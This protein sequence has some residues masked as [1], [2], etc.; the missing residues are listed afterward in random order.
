MH[1]NEEDRVFIGTWVSEEVKKAVE[2]GYR[3]GKIFEIWQ[4]KITQY[5]PATGQGGLFPGYID[6]FFKQKTLA[7]GF[8]AECNNDPEA[9]D[10]YIQDFERAEGIKLDKSQINLNPGKRSVAKLCLNSLWGKYGQREN[11]PKTEIVTELQR[12]VEMLTTPEV[13]VI[14]YLPANDYTLYVYWRYTEEAMETSPVTN[15]VVAAYT[16][17]Q[18]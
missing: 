9:I 12:L 3:T 7:S 5:N 6:E 18:A 8:P 4:Y 13:E 17:A 10:Q 14:A 11:M 1:E 2:V 15:V 16:T